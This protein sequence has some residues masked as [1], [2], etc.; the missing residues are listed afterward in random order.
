MIGR[1]IGLAA[2]IAAL[3]LLVALVRHAAPDAMPTM[4]EV[5]KTIGMA[6]KRARRRRSRSKSTST[7]SGSRK[8][9]T[10]SDA[11]ASSKTAS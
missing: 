4:A 3:G 1:L 7:R 10:T 9:S 2:T 11:S 8:R 6:P 5:R